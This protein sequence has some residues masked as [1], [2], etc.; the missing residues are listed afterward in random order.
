M[1]E[2]R[3]TLYSSAGFENFTENLVFEELDDF[4]Q[5][6]KN[7]SPQQ[8]CLCNICLAD[9]AAIVLNELKPYYCSNFIDKNKYKDYHK[10]HKLEVQ[11]EIVKAFDIVKQN[12]HHAD[13]KVSSKEIKK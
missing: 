9:V 6:A 10:K 5:K 1:R 13:D 12:P 11:R 8:F 4:I 2:L 3:H 7:K